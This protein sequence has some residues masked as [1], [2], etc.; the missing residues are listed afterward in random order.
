MDDKFSS[1]VE[2]AL[3]SG[4]YKAAV[5]PVSKIE[6]DK[7]FRKLCE[8]NHCGNFGRSWM[9]PPLIGEIDELIEKLHTFGSALVFQTVGELEDSYD[10]EGM[11]EAE[12]FHN[13]LV[14]K[15]GGIV[16]EE[17][18]HGRMLSLGAGGCRICDVCAKRSNEPCR[19]PEIAL[20]SLEGYGVNVYKLAEATG[21]KYINGDNTVTYFGAVLFG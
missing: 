18:D 16:A 15:V 14:L 11:M 4:A 5:I 21:M 9:C 8:A 6:T 17:I 1:L 7:Y 3:E 13:R 10:F 19:H 20:A 12:A 2:K